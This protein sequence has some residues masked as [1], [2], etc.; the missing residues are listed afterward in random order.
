[1][2]TTPRKARILLKQ[3]NAKVI[4]KEPFTIQ[5]L[6]ATGETKQDITLGVDSGSKVIGLS[7]TTDKEE[8]FSAEVVLRNDI[9]DLLSA[10]RQNRRIRRNMLRYRESRFLNR[11]STKSV[12]YKIATHLRVVEKL[13]Q[14]LPITK[15]IVEVASFDIQKI[16]NP[17]I[18]GSD[19]QQG[20][21]LGFWNV[22]EY[23][24]FR[25]NHSCQYCKDKS[26][27]KIL[28]VHHIKSRK[29]GGDSPDNLITLCETCHDKYHRG[30]IELNIK[31]GKVLKDA[32]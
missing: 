18:Q 19:Y 12:K 26:K 29:I 6:T 16:K 10:R 14:I 1:M 11:V 5:L 15:I 8:L 28:N 23:V 2:P 27:D 21:Q 3:G 31:R 25:D 17:D 9:V 24:L 13:H 30:K 4:K 22:R 7:A 32:T 20:E